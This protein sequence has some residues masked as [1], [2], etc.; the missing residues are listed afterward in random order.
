M[1]NGKRNEK[2]QSGSIPATGAWIHHLRALIKK[3]DAFYLLMSYLFQTVLFFFFKT[4]SSILDSCTQ[5]YQIF[6][7]VTIFDLL[8]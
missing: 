7:N 3:K 6:H 2:N 1:A 5:V 4:Q 8:L